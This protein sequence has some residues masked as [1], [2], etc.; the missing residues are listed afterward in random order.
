MGEDITAAL[1]LRDTVVE[2][3]ITPNRPDCC[4]V[5]GLAREAGATFKRR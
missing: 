5:I 3:E 1:G 2:Y 4:S